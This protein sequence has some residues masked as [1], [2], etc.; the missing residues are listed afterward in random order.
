[1][2][3]EILNKE[4]GELIDPQRA[5]VEGDWVRE[6]VGGVVTEYEYHEPVVTTEPAI[7]IITVRQFLKRFTQAERIAMRNSTD[8]IVIDLYTDLTLASYVDLDDPELIPGLMYI[9]GQ[10]DP[11]ISSPIILPSRIADLT[12][13]GTQQEAYNGIL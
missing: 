5:P 9:S 2:T 13:D 3:I 10:T 4:T 8:D 7:R 11:A 1:M 6:T 12:V